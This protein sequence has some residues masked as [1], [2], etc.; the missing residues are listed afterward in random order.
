MSETVGEQPHGGS[1]I[2]QL[3]AA[4]EELENRDDLIFASGDRP[5]RWSLLMAELERLRHG[6]TSE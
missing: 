4:L 2:E 1:T 6:R 5:M 3:E